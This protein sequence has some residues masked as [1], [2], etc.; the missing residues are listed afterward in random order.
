MHQRGEKTG[1]EVIHA[2]AA[3]FQTEHADFLFEFRNFL[4]L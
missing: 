1:D 2:V 3:M 4:K